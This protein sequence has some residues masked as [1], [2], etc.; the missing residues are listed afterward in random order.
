ML[1]KLV[2]PVAIAALAIAVPALSSAAPAPANLALGAAASAS[3]AESS[4]YDA[5][6][7]IDGDLSTRWS[8]A[9]SDPQTLEVDLGARA[10]IGQITLRW[11]AAY[12]RAYMLEVSSDRVTWTPVASASSSDGGVDDY[13]GLAATG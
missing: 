11:E 8:S 5:A 1:R 7:A 3:S 6:N 10:A 13:P 4:S 12:G 2:L 9:F